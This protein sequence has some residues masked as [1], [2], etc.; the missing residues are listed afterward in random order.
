[1]D[2]LTENDKA[3]EALLDEAR[4]GDPFEPPRIE[5]CEGDP[6]NQV[7]LIMSTDSGWVAICIRRDGI[8]L[9]DM[10]PYAG[11]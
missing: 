11:G 4:R 7:N 10:A 6:H 9:G 8:W 1:M 5:R 2:Q 3:F